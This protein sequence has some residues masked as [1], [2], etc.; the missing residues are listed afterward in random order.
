MPHLAQGTLREIG[1]DLISLVYRALN[2]RQFSGPGEGAA[3]IATP[4]VGRRNQ[5]RP[6]GEAISHA[7]KLPRAFISHQ[8]RRT[9]QFIWGR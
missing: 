2:G 8:L 3:I 5:M 6:P 4:L 9:T 7:K 1:L